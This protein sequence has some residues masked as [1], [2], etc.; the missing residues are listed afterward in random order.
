MY[1]WECAK[2][3]GLAEEEW[4]KNEKNQNNIEKIASY[5]VTECGMHQQHKQQNIRYDCGKKPYFWTFV[6]IWPCFSQNK[7]TKTLV[8]NLSFV[9]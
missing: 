7:T 2:N 6:E 8:N 1:N 5:H 4:K 9:N 3:G